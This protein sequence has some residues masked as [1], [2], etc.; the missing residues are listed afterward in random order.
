MVRASTHPTNVHMILPK[1]SGKWRVLAVGAL[2]AVALWMA[3]SAVVAWKF[4]R[5]SR[6]FAEP[7]PA[8][9]WAAIESRRL[10]TSDGQEIGGWLVRG[11]RS[12]G[13]VLLLHGV[14]SSRARNVACDASG[15]P[16]PVTPSL[17]S[18]FVRMATRRA[19]PMISVGVPGTTWLRQCVFYGGSFPDGRF[20]LSAVR[21]GRRRRFFRPRSLG[22][23][24]AGYF[25]EQPYKDLPQRGVEPAAPPLAADPGL[26]R[27]R[28]ACG[29]G[30]R[31]FSRWT[32]SR[33]RRTEHIG[34]IPE[35]VPIVLASGSADRHAP[36]DEVTAAFRSRPVARPAGGIRGSSPRAT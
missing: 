19:R 6:P 20:L 22:T 16:K 9:A 18:R 17:R 24:V 1:F 11:D 26:D 13:C 32:W 33:F 28:R 4:T 30:R 34:D 7:P 25:L 5:R 15:L 10:T 21:W 3:S 23:D 2:V 35:D 8:V 29:F 14:D 27:L 31:C 12:K 36:L